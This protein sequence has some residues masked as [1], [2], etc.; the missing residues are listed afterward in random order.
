MK[1]R[2]SQ[3]TGKVAKLFLFLA[4][5]ICR[6]KMSRLAS[7]RSKGG[8][9]TST[10]IDEPTVSNN[11]GREEYVSREEKIFQRQLES[12]IEM[13]RKAAIESA[14]SGSELSQEHGIKSDPIKVVLK[15][16]SIEENYTVTPPRKAKTRKLIISDEDS[17]DE[18]VGFEPK[19]KKS[20]IKKIEEKKETNKKSNKQSNPVKNNDLARSEQNRSFE[21]EIKLTKSIKNNLENEKPIKNNEIKPNVS[22]IKSEVISNQADKKSSEQKITKGADD[23]GDSCDKRSKLPNKRRQLVVSDD[24]DL[25]ESSEEEEIVEKKIPSKAKKTNYTA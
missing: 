13:S 24:S 8:P 10:Q 25:E 17:D 3:I 12:A 4:F 9:I 1:K 7:R 21:C 23:K 5:D 2:K 18:F 11:S 6:K 16:K 14:S 22:N 19:K 15:R 20:P